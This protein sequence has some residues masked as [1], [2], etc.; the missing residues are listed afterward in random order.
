MVRTGDSSWVSP[1]VRQ[2]GQR[3]AQDAEDLQAFELGKVVT[4][5]KLPSK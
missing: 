1:G 3:V 2:P 4:E 5:E